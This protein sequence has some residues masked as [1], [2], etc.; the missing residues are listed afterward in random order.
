MQVQITTLTESIVEN[1][2]H[3]SE[4]LTSPIGTS[5]NR[6]SEFKFESIGEAV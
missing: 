3:S 1:C 6:P 2:Q 5:R 4:S